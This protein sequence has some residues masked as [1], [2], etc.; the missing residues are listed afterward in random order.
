[1]SEQNILQDRITGYLKQQEVPQ[2]DAAAIHDRAAAQRASSNR[3]LRRRGLAIGLLFL[4][5]VIA[6]AYTERQAFEAA[7]DLRLH[8]EGF[9]GPIVHEEAAPRTLTLGTLQAAT[10]FHVILPE[11]M[12][13]GYRLTLLQANGSDRVS[14][15]YLGQHYAI[16]VTLTPR[17]PNEYFPPGE[18]VM[19][20]DDRQ[21]H[22]KREVHVK[23][24]VLLVGNEVMRIFSNH[25]TEAQLA[26]IKRATGA[27]DA[28]GPPKGAIILNP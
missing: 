12:P 27:H 19:F 24:H 2:F 26:N 23:Q 17:R 7:V 5:P 4:A 6:V 1:M 20:E 14:A 13:P 10:S 16:M 3:A 25:L 9:K 28:P 15:T 21:G 11:G 18:M 8:G 22:I